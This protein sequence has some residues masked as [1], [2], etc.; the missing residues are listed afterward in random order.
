MDSRT[1]KVYLGKARHNLKNPV[2]AILG[3][4]EML[5]EDCEDEGLLGIVEDLEKLYFAGKEILTA[6][7]INF[8]DQSLSLAE[9]KIS[10]IGKQ[11]ELDIRTPLNTIIGYSELIIEDNPNTKIETFHSDIQKIIDSG[12]NLEKELSSI[13]S[14]DINSL[15]IS[16]SKHSTNKNINILEDVLKS[17]QPLDKDD[18]KSKIFGKILAV[19]DNINN[20][21][22]LKKRMEK[23]GHQVITANDGEEAL[24]ELLNSKNDI[25]VVLLDTF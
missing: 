6:I 25:D 16:E 18:K 21:S 7:E 13:I 24:L 1:K 17:I 12:R 10:D 19:D 4:S 8:S 14:F 22:L 5:I 3:Y 20:T 23:K 11:T 2:N 9:K 15:N